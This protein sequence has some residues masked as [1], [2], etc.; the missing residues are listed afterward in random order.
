MDFTSEE[1]KKG[2]GE[3][4]VWSETVSQV[5]SLVPTLSWKDPNPPV[6]LGTPQN[7][8]LG[9]LILNHH[10]VDK[11]LRKVSSIMIIPFYC[12]F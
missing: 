12:L 8:V 4:R 6:I 5:G 11:R 3:R 10:N 9:W 2:S 7:G 1:K